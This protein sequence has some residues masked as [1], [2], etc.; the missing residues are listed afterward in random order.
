MLDLRFQKL[1][2]PSC[3]MY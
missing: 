3:S 1:P 2:Y